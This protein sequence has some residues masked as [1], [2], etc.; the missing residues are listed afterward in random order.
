MAKKVAHFLN[1][2]AIQSPQTFPLVTGGF[3]NYSQ[4]AILRL[5]S[6]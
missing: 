1:T 4:H 5:S 6:L 3:Q 2:K